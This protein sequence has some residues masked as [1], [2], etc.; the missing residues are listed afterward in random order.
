M[1]IVNI[2]LLG[3]EQG[4]HTTLNTTDTRFDPIDGFLSPLPPELK[5][6]LE[7]WQLTYR[8]L[9][10][11]RSCFS[12][13]TAQGVIRCSAPG[14]TQTVKAHLNEWLNS[15]DRMWQPIR[16]SLIS[17]ANQLN[18][19]NEE[20]HL[21]LDIQDIEL[22]HFPLQE[23]N[24]I[25]QHYPKAE[26]ILRVRGQAGNRISPPQSCSRIRILVV[27]GRSDGINT[28]SDL[29]V[30]ENLEEKGA[31]VISLIKPTFQKLCEALWDKK[32]Y[33]IFIFTGHSSSQKDGQIGWIDLN[34]QEE[35]SIGDF[36]N[37][38]RQA[39]DN[40][41]QLAIFNSCDG[42]GL[43]YQLA[44]LNLPRSI[45]MREPVPDLVAIDFLKYLFEEFTSN[46][47]LF[48][49]V[50]IARKRLEHFN[51]RY[52]GATWLPLMCIR[53]SAL[54]TPFI[55]QGLCENS[56]PEPLIEPISILTSQ[57]RICK[58][59]LIVVVRILGL[60]VLSISIGFFGSKL[61]IKNPPSI[62]PSFCP[63]KS[64]PSQQNAT[65]KHITY[66]QCFADVPNVPSSETW[67]R[68][69]ST[70]WAVFRPEIDKKLK[71]IFGINLRTKNPENQA[72]ASGIG[73]QMLIEG[74]LN[75]AES[76]EHIN[77]T[78]RQEAAK[79]GF[80]LKEEAV[81]IDA[82]AI[83]VHPNLNIKGLTI[84]QLRD[85]YTG[86]ITNWSQVNGPDIPITKYSRSLS[87]GTTKTFLNDYLGLKEL[88][89]NVVPVKDTSEALNKVAKNEGAIYFASAP[90]VVTQCGVKPIPIFN[91]NKGTFVAPYKG[92]LVPHENCPQ[93]RNEINIEAFKNGE[94][95]ITRRLFVI[96]KQDGKDN[97]KAG[98]TYAR[99][100]LTDEGQKLIEQVK[101][102]RIR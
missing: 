58:A 16:D 41:L 40:G 7:N 13:L 90:E 5:S 79:R 94:Y 17:I 42:L 89:K 23:W 55:W 4:Y 50:H 51:L 83:I 60:V 70:T 54:Y 38:L 96:I 11:V 25:E 39:I 27:V 85:I 82:I 15:G 100:L 66:P 20:I 98:E 87:S 57:Q 65:E 9:K 24:I 68:G 29:K 33:H 64:I 93:Q 81:A 44:Q 26:V 78:Q 18:H 49:S 31:E 21:L 34:D 91:D 67:N 73:I 69:G 6:S 62:P 59:K 35:L 56:D 75:F 36:K 84:N 99:L 72:P 12:R 43:A 86:N 3:A 1:I 52:P 32:G 74:Q 14:E 46:K 30:I 88:G 19:T 10:D 37:A 95:P 77:E 63:I 2:K 22:S 97:Q 92:L 47:S 102:V 101:W 53:Q 28:Q 48:T 45:V 61:L 80:Q 8:D 76:S 71:Q